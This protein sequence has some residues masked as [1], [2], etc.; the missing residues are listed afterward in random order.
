M[1]WKKKK[2]PDFVSPTQEKRESLGDSVRGSM[3][4]L[5]DGK[6]LADTV[7]GKNIWFI[8][9]LTGLGLIYINNGYNTEKLHMYR[10]KL[11]GE[12]KELRFEAITTTSELMKLSTQSQVLRKIREAGLELQE[13]TEPPVK[14]HKK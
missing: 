11:E 10:V 3:K 6:I 9:F 8:L 1:F 12:L 14:L 13:S 7:I 2:Q 4:E 5:L